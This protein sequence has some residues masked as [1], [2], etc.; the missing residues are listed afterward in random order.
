MMYITITYV[1]KG[2]V[3]NFFHFKRHSPSIIYDNV[4]LLSE[5]ISFITVKDKSKS[6]FPGDH[7]TTA[8]L[9]AIFSRY[10]MG[11]KLGFFA[12]LYAV[13]FCLP[14][15]ICGAHWATD[16]IMGSYVIALVTTCIALGTPIQ[17]YLIIGFKKSLR[18]IKLYQNIKA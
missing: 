17:Y 12:S 11:K 4:T 16:I 18:A 7:A 8:I 1:N 15:L 14:R 13:F 5:K 3:T 10:F 6:S 2:I 9:F